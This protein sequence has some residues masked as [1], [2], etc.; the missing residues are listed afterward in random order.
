MPAVAPSVPEPLLLRED[1]DGIAT[2]TLNRGAAR[3]ALS[4]G[5]M[6]ALH[7][8]L[9]VIRDDR[10]VR[11]VVLRGAGPAFCAGHDLK[12]MRADP[13]ADSV[14]ALFEACSA[15]MLA[16]TRLPQPVIAQVHGVAT[17]AGC[18]LVATCDL[19]I[20]SEEARFATPGVQIGLF[21]ST[22]MVALSRAVPR[23]AA[24]EMLLLGEP[25]DAAEAL[26]IGLVNRVVPASDLAAG[27]RALAA[28]IAAKAPRVLAI[29][30]KAFGRQAELGLAEA[31]ADASAVM[32]R[33]MLMAEAAEGIDAFLQ[34]R[35][36]RW[37][38]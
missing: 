23:K 7:G 31:Y 35:P 10:S 32:T 17:A 22:P 9:D 16:I 25:I 26:R 20:C 15:L 33:N 28:R 8:A 4:R 13:S 29:G 5:L 38:T 27:A 19:A 12:E 11:V 34:K 18:Q 14:R 2:L 30:K 37:D 21:C 36:P 1:A 24:M 3:N 6:A